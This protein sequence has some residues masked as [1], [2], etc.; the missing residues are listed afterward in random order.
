MPLYLIYRKKD[1]K[2]AESEFWGSLKY[3]FDDYSL[4]GF[5][6][7]E[8]SEVFEVFRSKYNNGYPVRYFVVKARSKTV[9]EKTL[10]KYFGDMLLGRGQYSPIKRSSTT[11]TYQDTPVQFLAILLKP[12]VKLCKTWAERGGIELGLVDYGSYVR[13]EKPKRKNLDLEDYQSNKSDWNNL[14]NY[15]NEKFKR[16]FRK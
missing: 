8:A 2:E 4:A 10:K 16:S 9:L 12:K 6:P 1:D 5:E 3:S 13:S 11:R 15:H 14:K 7:I